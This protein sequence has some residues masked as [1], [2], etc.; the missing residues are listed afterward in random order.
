MVE[1][2]YS[3]N[4]K[5]YIFCQIKNEF[6]S[7]MLK[8]NLFLYERVNIFE[9]DERVF[10]NCGQL[11]ECSFLSFDYFFILPAIFYSYCEGFFVSQLHF[12]LG[13]MLFLSIKMQDFEIFE[14]SKK[15]KPECKIV[16]AWG[17][18]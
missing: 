4:S 7:R 3:G 18:P 6:F 10:S 9:L 17:S 14:I 15:K 8:G 13:W 11:F 16:D 2:L 1:I 12:L 5:V